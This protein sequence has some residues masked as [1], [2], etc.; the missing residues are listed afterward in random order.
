MKGRLFRPCDVVLEVDLLREVHLGGDGGEDESLLTPVR[1][2]ELDLPVQTAGSKESRIEG[3]LTVGGHD[4]L[5]IKLI[6][7]SKTNGKRR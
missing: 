7:V 4:H 2:R 5:L 3:V 1:Q 6:K